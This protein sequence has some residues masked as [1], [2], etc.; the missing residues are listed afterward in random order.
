MKFLLFLLL[1]S[2]S[3]KADE[4]F[5]GYGMGVFNSTDTKILNIG[6][7]Q[8]LYGGFYWSYKGGFWADTS[9]DPTKSS[10]LF[11][12]TGPGFLIDLNPV[13]I[14]NGIGLSAI[15][16][17]DSMLGGAFPQFQEDLSVTLRDIHGNGIGVQYSHVSS[18]GIYNPNIGR[19]FVIIELSQ[20]W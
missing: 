10:S 8:D 14:R 5:M 3:A 7:R 13:E 19:D 17:P 2:I 18:A 12:S 4:V 1:I 11:A 15:S 20:R 6:Y 16:N 9:G